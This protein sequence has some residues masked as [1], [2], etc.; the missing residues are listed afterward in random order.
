MPR[1]IYIIPKSMK[2][3]DALAN[4]KAANCPEI[5]LGIP[6]RLAGVIDEASLPMVFEEP[7]IP[8]STPRDPLTEID[9]LE[10]ELNTTKS[11]LALRVEE[12]D[13]IKDKLADYDNLKTRVEILE[14]KKV[15]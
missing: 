13:N 7:E 6:P 5:V 11:N 4:A 10:L 12:V 1:R 9:K 3:E 8:Y 15:V 2:V 14:A